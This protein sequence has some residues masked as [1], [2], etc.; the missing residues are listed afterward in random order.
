M[1]HLLQQPLAARLRPTTLQD[2]FGQTHLLGAG[3]PLRHAITQ[4]VLHS[5][6]LWGPPGTGKTTLAHLIAQGA[7][8][9]A[10]SAIFAG[11]QDIRAIARDANNHQATQSQPSVLFIDEIHRFNK[12]QQD[13]LLPFVE[14]GTFTL[15]GA[16]TENPSFA[17]NRALLSRIR[18]YVLQ[19]LSTDELLSIIA[20]ALQDQERGLGKLP[21]HFPV[22]LQKILAS[23][24]DG[25]ARY[26]LN[27]LAML[28]DTTTAQNNPQN[29]PLDK[30]WCITREL[31]TSLMQDNLR[32]FDKHGDHFYDQISAL[33]KAVRGSSPDAALYWFMRMLDGGCDP[34]YLARR[35]IRM[36]SEDIGNADP[37]ALTVAI[38]ACEAYERLGSPEGE[39]AIAQAII[40][41]SCTAKSNA[42]Y[43]AF[44][45][46]QDEIK[47]NP[48]FAVPL[49]LRNAPTHLMRALGYGKHYRYAHDEPDAYAANEHY[50]PVE[51][52][53]RVYYQP[54]LQGLE[55]HF[56]EKL[57]YLKQQDQLAQDKSS[58]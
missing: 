47:K 21:I 44:K 57:A 3:K 27:V 49:H 42:V 50:F 7:S 53:P 13:A 55:K 35:V 18:V 8:F 38:H 5:M 22:D 26:V 14:N 41:L 16:T 46:A 43:V 31:L 25:D 52:A 24:A 34:L 51:M 12:A 19:P 39:L 17:L 32:H 23:G 29:N 37:Q 10:I 20:R 4:G 30:P 36:A 54:T 1:T 28:A 9:H 48:S 40:Y 15:I 11:V 2:F 56:R 33:H 6:I 58:K 45:A